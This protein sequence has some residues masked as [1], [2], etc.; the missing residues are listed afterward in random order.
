MPL[1][2]Q[3]IYGPALLCTLFPSKFARFNKSLYPS[4]IFQAKYKEIKSN[5][6]PKA[7]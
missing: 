2:S 6:R 7:L 1:L 5:S 3:T 4:P